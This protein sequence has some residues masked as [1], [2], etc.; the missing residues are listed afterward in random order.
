MEFD[1]NEVKFVS[2]EEELSLNEINEFNSG[3]GNAAGFDFNRG[4]EVRPDGRKP[5][6]KSDILQGQRNRGRGGSSNS[7][8]F[9]NN[10]NSNRF[11]QPPRRRPVSPTRNPFFQI[12]VD[13]QPRTPRTEFSTTTTAR[14]FSGT[15][16]SALF[17]PGNAATFSPSFSSTPP[18]PLAGNDFSLT[19]DFPADIETPPFFDNSDDVQPEEPIQPAARPVSPPRQ[20]FPSRPAGGRP[21][22]KSDEQLRQSGRPRNRGRVPLRRPARP[23][24]TVT[25]DEAPRTTPNRGFLNA[26]R[27]VEDEEPTFVGEIDEF[28]APLATRRPVTSRPV[29]SRR[30]VVRKRPRKP[31]GSRNNLNSIDDD[32][33]NPFK[34]PPTRVADGRKPRVKSDIKAR[35][36]N[37]HNPWQSRQPKR[38]RV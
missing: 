13:E 4:P 34:C 2:P 16:S 19:L 24:S 26:I 31:V 22:V 20:R 21:R 35:K 27:P 33:S 9:N 28:D 10:N 25:L 1:Q 14:P 5:R 15:Q 17:N 32:C 29:A 8:R 36:R 12:P 30:P 38:Q 11:N 37:Y 7:N 3:Q 23:G 18:P 6:V